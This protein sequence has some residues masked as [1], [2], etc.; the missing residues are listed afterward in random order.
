MSDPKSRARVVRLL[1]GE[2]RPDDLTGLFLYARDHC[3]GREDI[4]AFVAHH[5]ERDRGIITRSTRDWF[6]VARFHMSR[7]TPDG[8]KDF[9]ADKMPPATKEYLSIIVNRLDAHALKEETGLSRAEAYRTIQGVV[10]RMV[11]N[12]DGTWSL[13]LPLTKK[14]LDL[15]QF[16]VTMM[17]VRPAFESK[18]LIDD[19]FATLKSNGLITKE[20]I[21]ERG[22]DL[23][24]LVQLYAVSAMHNCTVQIGD[25]SQTKLKAVA[26][27]DE[28]AV[29]ADVHGAAPAYPGAIITTAMFSAKLDPIRYCH[30]EL[31]ATRPW[32]MEIEV[33]P[34]RILAPLR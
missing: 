6:A 15:I 10:P 7:F 28:I 30:P 25:G 3:D 13:P 24:V 18:Q 4:G 8:P 29:L 14:E 20:E 32:D 27:R 26:E 34:E 23:S 17:V 11:K 9:K 33:T 12:S 16:A 1:T 5:H 19:F 21:R 22:S 31:L 2:F